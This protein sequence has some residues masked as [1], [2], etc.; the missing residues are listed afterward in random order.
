[1]SLSVMLTHDVD[2]TQS[3]KNAVDYAAYEHS[4]G[5][6]GT[7]F[8][9][10]KYIRD[11]N[12]DIFFNDEG[13][14]HLGRL[15]E[16]GMELGSHTIAHSKVFSRFPMGTGREAYPSYVPFVKDRQTVFNASILGELRVSKFLIDHFSGQRIVSFRP[17]EL[18]NPVSLPEALLATGFRYSSTTT[19]NAS[20]THLPYQL[21]YDRLMDSEV[22]IF[23]FPVTIEDEELPKLGDRLPQALEVARRISRYGGSMVVLIHPNILDHKLA[24]EKGFVEG[25]RPYAWFGS[26]GE[27]GRWWAARN[28]VE[29]DV[30]RE[31]TVMCITLTV[32]QPVA[33][34]T[35]EVPE[36]WRLMLSPSSPKGI[37]QRGTVVTF[38]ELQGTQKIQ[39]TSSV[40]SQVSHLPSVRAARRRS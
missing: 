36:G 22:D 24:F 31:A 16:L 18:S 29:V 33:G 12:D 20:L 7:Y 27:F 10:V 25:V 28:Q 21:N 38:P 32:P 40:T 39:F 19:A 5:L 6:V 9:Q 35:V 26:M 3:M 34:L 15:A 8:I 1:M 37:E 13:V 4:Q 17:G 2:F 14:R 23:E 30:V 11:Y